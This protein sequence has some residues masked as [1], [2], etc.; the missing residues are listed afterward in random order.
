MDLLQ[1]PGFNCELQGWSAS[2]EF[3]VRRKIKI[4]KTK[5]PTQSKKLKVT[6]ETKKKHQLQKMEKDERMN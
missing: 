5:K 2:R 6:K 3:T 1:W 4:Y